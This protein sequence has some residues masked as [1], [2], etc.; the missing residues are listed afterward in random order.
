MRAASLVL[1]IIVCQAVGL[2]GGRWT[3][4]EIPAWYRSLLKPW[5]NP[6][7]WI[8]APVWT[9]L[10][11]LMALAAWLIAETEGSPQRT[12]ALVLFGVQLA[13]NLAWSW[14]FFRRHAIRAAL[15]EIV[16]MW[17]AIGVT[18]VAFARIVPSAGGAHGSLLGLGHLCHS[19]ERD[20]RPSQSSPPRLKDP[21]PSPK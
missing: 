20:Y 15:A 7:S 12:S 4:P 3:A 14:I 5:F 10:Y 1:W 8:F 6:P 9:T 11:L 19:P 17:I 2:L 13:L 21:A 16:L 18:N